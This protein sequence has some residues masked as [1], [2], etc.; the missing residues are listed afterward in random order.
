M[1]IWVEPM[2]AGKEAEANADASLSVSKSRFGVYVPGGGVPQ[3]YSC[4]EGVHEDAQ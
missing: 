1:W 3:W 2:S 4:V